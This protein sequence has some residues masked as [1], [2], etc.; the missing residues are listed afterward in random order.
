MNPND[1]MEIEGALPEVRENCIKLNKYN[2]NL[3]EQ[4][5][6]VNELIKTIDLDL[7]GK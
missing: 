1:V 7:E 4:N 5:V 2:S 6:K 3:T